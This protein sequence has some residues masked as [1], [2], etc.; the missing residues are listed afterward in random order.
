VTERVIL[1][2]DMDAFYASV[3]IRDRP[4]LRGLPVIV[5]GLSDRG[6][7]SAASYE[8]RKFGV[9][10]AMP[11]FRAKK[12]CPQGVFL[13]GDMKRYAEASR[14][15][16]RVFG[17]FTD[18]IEPLALDEAFLDI[19]GSLK[20]LGP[21]RSIAERLKARVLE[22]TRLTVSVGV[23]PNK[24]VAKIAC[25][26]SKPDGLFI[27]SAEEARAFLAPLPVRRLF[28]VGPKAERLLIPL[29]IRT[30]GD[31]ARAEE[32][33]AALALG[34]FAGE[35][36]QRAQGIDDR[37]VDTSRAPKGIGEESTFPSDVESRDE[38]ARAIIVHAEAVA[39]RARRA[40]Y[41]GRTVSLKLRLA[42]K[43]KGAITS[44]RDLFP[45][46]SR[47]TKLEKPTSEG[48]VI[49]AA[50]LKLLSQLTPLPKVR[51]LGVTLSDLEPR[52]AAAEASPQAK[53]NR[54]EPQL[55]LFARPA[56][57]PPAPPPEPE[58]PRLGPVLDA[59]NGKF[60]RGT[61][62][63]AVQGLE[64]L[65]PHDRAKLGEPEGDG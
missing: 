15:I 48:S 54:G 45:S 63:R 56:P 36:I 44:A 20:L 16:H 18:L 53:P 49:E 26:H 19:T 5:G 24:L 50:A 47:Q 60:G 14:Q 42:A 23:G 3:E 2:A 28:G 35:M 58:R 6:V 12:L 27:V 64:K 41:A 39:A 59:I 4:E 8:A 34:R 30:I 9:R 43:N 31:L 62:R 32:R 51:L 22:E 17:E 13:P 55:D 11:T 37:P 33:H 61:L 7:V 29:G 1:H 21:A 25:G 57:T 46:L 38:L 52:Q 40:G 65:S 10:S